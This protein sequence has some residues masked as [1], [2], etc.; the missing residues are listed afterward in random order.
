MGA[1]R[2]LQPDRRLTLADVA[3]IGPDGTTIGSKDLAE[4]IRFAG[5]GGAPST[6]DLTMK[7]R[8]L[9]VLCSKAALNRDLYHD[10]EHVLWFIAELLREWARLI[11][12]DRGAPD[13][14]PY[15]VTVEEA[16]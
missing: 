1:V 7:M 16:P 3:V 14:A 8:G 4:L 12:A 13:P 15:A 5:S 10:E 6:D 2:S 9:S 11:D